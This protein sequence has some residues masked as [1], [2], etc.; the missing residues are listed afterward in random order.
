M[1]DPCFLWIDEP[2]T[3][4][5][6]GPCG[7]Q[8]VCAVR[9][10]CVHEHVQEFRACPG[11]AAD[12]Q[13]AAGTGTLTCGRCWGFGAEPHQCFPFTVIDW[14]EGYRE[15]QPRTV[16]QQASTGD[17]R[18]PFAARGE[19]I[20]ASPEADLYVTWSHV[21]ESPLWTGTRAQALAAGCPEERLKRAGLN[22][23]SY[24]FPS[25]PG[26][27]WNRHGLIAEQRGTLARAK[28]SAYTAAWMEDR[29]TEAYQMLEP[30]EDWRDEG[31]A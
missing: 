25:E 18:E 2:G 24:F 21:T 1:G 27:F 9:F 4:L 5:H 8:T 19:V 13:H 12:V 23:S 28:L 15:P 30:F 20:K 26:L 22:G 6:G 16:V 31:D 10:G 3:Q 7:E 29:A 17:R 11:C 14:D